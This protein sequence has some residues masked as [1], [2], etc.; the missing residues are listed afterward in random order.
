MLMSNE[1]KGYTAQRPSPLTPLLDGPVITDDP[2]MLRALLPLLIFNRTLDGL[3]S[4]KIRSLY[5]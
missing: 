4:I 1:I 3:P 5:P 2:G